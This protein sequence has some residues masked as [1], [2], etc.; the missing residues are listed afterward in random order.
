[1]HAIINVPANMKIAIRTMCGFT[2]EGRCYPKLCYLPLPAERASSF[3]AS[4]VFLFIYRELKEREEKMIKVTGRKL[5]IPQS[6]KI[7][8]FQGDNLCETRHFL[9][10]DNNI[11]VLSFKLDVLEYDCCIDLEK[12]KTETGVL[13][14]WQITSGITQNG[15]MLNVQL[16]GFNTENELVWHSEIETFFVGDSVN[17]S[18]KIENV[19]LTEFEQI[20]KRATLAKNEAID[21][22][23]IAKE[24][25]QS[26]ED[27][28]D[29]CGEYAKECEENVSVFSGVLD[30]HKNDED[31][32]HK[33]TA[34][35]VGA[36]STSEIDVALGTKANDYDLYTHK[37]DRSNPHGVTA[38]QVGAYTKE[39]T[40]GIVNLA[41]S[42]S[43][44]S[45]NEKLSKKADIEHTHR[46]ALAE[47]KNIPLTKLF[48]DGVLTYVE[49]A[50]M[51]GETKITDNKISAYGA[52]ITINYSG[53]A[54]FDISST[55][56]DLKI[57]GIATNTYSFKGYLEEG[58]SFSVTLGDATLNWYQRTF[59]GGFMSGEDKEKLDTLSESVGNIDTALDELHAYAQGLISG[60][61]SE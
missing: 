44:R 52:D 45:I 35:Q 14:T 41:V 3:I 32:P 46:E 12:E 4:G 60:G 33:V 25:L 8:G 7:L 30:I 9:I 22:A 40:N 19:A 50:S 11:S 42:N 34:Q 51:P 24:H 56:S 36:Y 21:Y 23:L 59:S 27:V 10:T 26:C 39:E 1:M 55:V 37:V 2:S 20:E 31:N 29:E 6:D 18:K 5:Y 57:D 49:N 16:R 43:E 61:A 13:L 28:R 54:E 47:L 17:A 53:Y 48:E 15:G 58:I 38:G